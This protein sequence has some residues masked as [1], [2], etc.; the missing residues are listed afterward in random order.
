[1]ARGSRSAEM[2]GS[3]DCRG[4]GVITVGA[5]DTLSFPDWRWWFETRGML[6]T[7][8]LGEAQLP[9]MARSRCGCRSE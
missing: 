1:M 2:I 8:V 5:L 7:E 9:G 6:E 3:T 4:W